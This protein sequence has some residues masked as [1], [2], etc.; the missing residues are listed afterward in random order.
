MKTHYIPRLLLK[1]FAVSEKVNTYDFTTGSFAVKKV[2]N[3]FALNDG[4][5]ADLESAFATKLEGPFGDLLNHKLL[6]GDTITIDR[7]ENLLMRKFM[8]IN[9]LRAPIV[10]CSWD[11]MV[12]RTRT[13]DHPSVQAKEFLCRHNPELKAIFDKFIPSKE[14]YIRDL[15]KAMEIDSLEDIGNSCKRT[16]VSV[17]LRFAASHAMVTVAAFWDSSQ[18]GQEFILPKLPGV[19]QMDQV[20]TLYKLLVVRSLKARKEKD[21]IDDSIRRALGRLEYGSSVYCENFSVYPISPTRVL[22]CFSPYFRA[23]FPGMDAVGTVEIYPPL[24]DKEQFDKHFFEPMRMELFKPCRNAF[25]RYY[26]YSVKMLNAREVMALNALMLNM[27]TEE[28]VFHDFNK[29]RDSFWYYDRVAKF[30]V[31]KKHDFSHLG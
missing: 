30:A 14:T 19:S 16:D 18:S 11:E 24:L 26:Q 20:S 29:I 7:R 28:F 2:K 8:M 15:K 27:E 23:F 13:Q 1:Q 22:I 3:T 9:F 6:S 5:D 4:F 10:N 17:T 31:K 21:G 25:N 12:E